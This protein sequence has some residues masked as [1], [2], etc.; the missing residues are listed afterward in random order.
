[1]EKPVV[2]AEVPSIRA[3]FD[4][5]TMLFYAPDDHV[6]LADRVVELAA[7]E[8]LGKRLAENARRVFAQYSWARMRDVY[9][10]VHDE[11][12]PPSG[13]Q[14]KEPVAEAG[15]AGQSGG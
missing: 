9:V 2:C 13:P 11:L 7:D 15:E 8:A 3:I 5:E 1:M 4:E 12:L 14:A 10:G 6:G